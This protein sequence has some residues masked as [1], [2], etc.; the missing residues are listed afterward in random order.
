L[1][2]TFASYHATADPDLWALQLALGHA[3]L[4]TTQR[5]AHLKPSYRTGITTRVRFGRLAD[6]PT[7]IP[8]PR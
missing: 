7:I 2:H 5:Y 3:S 1:R 8:F 6:E 4:H